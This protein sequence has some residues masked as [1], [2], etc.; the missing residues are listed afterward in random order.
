MRCRV[1]RSVCCLLAVCPNM[2]GLLPVA[3]GG[4]QSASVQRKLDRRLGATDA[5]GG[6]ACLCIFGVERTL[7]GKAC[8]AGKQGCDTA[9]NQ[10][11][12]N[13]EHVGVPDFS[14]PQRASQTW[15]HTG[16]G[17]FSTSQLGQGLAESF[18]GAYTQSS[19]DPRPAH[20]PA[21]TRAGA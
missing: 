20:T 8:P 4:A 15:Y 9:T 5:V 11:P 19:F 1:V 2:G 16:G 3:G 17:V 18:C 7:S 6:P 13:K 10:C 12:E 14:Y 21:A